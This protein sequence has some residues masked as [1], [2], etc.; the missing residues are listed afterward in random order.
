MTAEC[1]D[2]QRYLIVR[3]QEWM[4]ALPLQEVAETMR[5]LP[6]TPLVDAPA[7]L[8]GVSIVRG[9]P[10]PVVSLAVL[11]GGREAGRARRFVTLRLKER[12]LALEV[13]EV[14]GLKWLSPGTLEAAPPLLR[15]VSAGH[16]EVLG[17][18]DGQMVAGLQL[19]RLLSE[20]LWARL[21]GSEVA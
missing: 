18:L 16:L 5:P 9:L 21:M 8:R 12:R 10:T 19:A 1:T 6:I 11:L 7:F 3:A 17:V 13:E 4:C 14:L 2:P 20:E 15:G